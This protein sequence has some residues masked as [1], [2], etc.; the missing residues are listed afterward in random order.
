MKPDHLYVIGDG[1]GAVKIGRSKD[2]AGRLDNLQ[3]GSSRVLSLLHVVHEAGGLE[4]V[5]HATF[6]DMHIHREWF[7]FGARDP[8]AEVQAAVADLIADRPPD[9]EDASD[10]RERL[11]ETVQAWGKERRAL[12]AERNPLV[13]AMLG[14]G[15]FGKEEIHQLTGLG[16][17]TIDRIEAAAK[18]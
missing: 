12:A 5:I 18:K 6:G 1:T 9:D 4:K 17:M 11:L 13:M 15:H 7:D 14:S 2:P 10:R 16:R 3:V 8:I